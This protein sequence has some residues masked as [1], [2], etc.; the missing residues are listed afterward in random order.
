MSFQIELLIRAANVLYLFA[1]MV[2]DILWLRILSVQPTEVRSASHDL[3]IKSHSNSES[4]RTAKA[5][6]SFVLSPLI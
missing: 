6:T 4:R 5:P 3:S 2:R 1:F